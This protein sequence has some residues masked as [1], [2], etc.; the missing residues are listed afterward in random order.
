MIVGVLGNLHDL[1]VYYCAVIII[2]V[3]II[4]V[5]AARWPRTYSAALFIILDLDNGH[6]LEKLLHHGPVPVLRSPQ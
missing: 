6:P 2:S 3:T 1:F 5:K 4:W